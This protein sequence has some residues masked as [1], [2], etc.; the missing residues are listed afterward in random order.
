MAFVLPNLSMRIIHTSDWHLG[1]QFYRY[2]RD[3]EHRHFFRQL[4][5]IMV[6]ERP[7]ALVVSGDIFHTAAPS[8]TAQALFVNGVITLRDASPDTV[9][10]ITA[11]NHD[12]PSRL[13]AY[14][15]LW[16]RNGVHLIGGAR[17]AANDL[18]DPEDMIVDV[19]G[20]GY[21]IAVPFFHPSNFP[22]ISPDIPR[23][24]RQKTFFDALLAHVQE[25]N[26]PVVLMAHVA[27]QGTDISAHDDA[28]RG[29]F[30]MEELSTM[31]E[32]YDYLA[33]GHIHTNQQLSERAWYCGTPIPVSFSEGN[34]HYVNLVDIP[35]HGAI[36]IVEKI[37]TELMRGVITLPFN[38]GN[39]EEGL[40]ALAQYSDGN[41]DYVR[42]LIDQEDVLPADAEERARTISE[43]KSYRF[44]EVRKKPR[45]QPLSHRDN[46]DIQEVSDF[47]QIDPLEL[48]RRHWLRTKEA[49][50]NPTL[51]ELMEFA[52]R[53]TLNSQQ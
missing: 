8:A 14:R 37:A 32:G 36:P 16:L 1:Q 34:E 53:Q 46:F 43:G 44:C 11:G 18:L 6:R 50:L 47:T 24:E 52:I 30:T 10:V 48:V 19:N 35:A 22:A 4:A 42:L 33:L 40:K 5:K 15:D 28:I 13:E 27:V 45:Q 12:S 31:G 49:E 29:G 38:G 51:T 26:L 21:I 2:D 39:F 9:I 41:M 20:K 23:E 17:R 7:D 25:A 3:D